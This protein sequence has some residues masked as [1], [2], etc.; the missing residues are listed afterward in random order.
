MWKKDSGYTK[1]DNL[2]CGYYLFN[3]PSGN[4][5]LRQ[6]FR[7]IGT[8][9]ELRS[10]A[11]SNSVGNLHR[12]GFLLPAERIGRVSFYKVNPRAGT[13]ALPGS[14]GSQPSTSSIPAKSPETASAA[15][16]AA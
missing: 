7:E 15:H 10:N 4:E 16:A 13:T 12:G 9:L 14:S 5:P 6:R 2:V 8:N 11:F 1:N 3:S